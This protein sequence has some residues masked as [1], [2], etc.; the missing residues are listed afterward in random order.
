MDGFIK[1]SKVFSMCFGSKWVENEFFYE[2]S[3]N[4]NFLATIMVGI[5]AKTDDASSKLFKKK[6]R[7]DNMSS[8][9][10]TF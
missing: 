9:P 6:I 3:F 1:V 10:V 7:V 2:K 8:T 4:L 5:L